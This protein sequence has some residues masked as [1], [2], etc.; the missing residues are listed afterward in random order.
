MDVQATLVSDLTVVGRV[1]GIHVT[2]PSPVTSA[3][4]FDGLRT[5]PTATHTV[6]D[7]HETPLRPSVP[8]PWWTHVVPPSVL[9]K[10]PCPTAT[11]LLIVGH[12]M[13][14]IVG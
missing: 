14:L 4:V 9:V 6:A 2:P 13:A 12:E 5:D 1:T 11:Q 10:M 7:G 8:L 3:R